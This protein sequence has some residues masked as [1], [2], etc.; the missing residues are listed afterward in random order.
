MVDKST[1]KKKLFIIIFGSDTRSGR[2]FD[3][4]LLISIILS[5]LVVFIDSV[6]YYHTNY[7]K[8]L[9]IAEWFFTV[10]F[11]VEYILRIITTKKKFSYI[12]SFYGVIDFLSIIPTYVSLVL[13]GTQ[14]LIV[15]RILRLLRV[16]RI[17]KL[18]RFIG[19]SS[20]LLASL[21]ASWHK[22]M[23]FLSV[24][25]TLVVIMGALM[26]LIE[27]QESGFSSIPKGIYWAIVTL[28]TVGYGDIAPQTFWG[29]T[30][31]SMIMILGYSIIAV[32][33]GIITAEMSRRRPTKNVIPECTHCNNIDHDD[34]AVYCKKCGKKLLK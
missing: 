6:G 30:L 14:F 23:V 11:T 10:L 17:L 33:T 4:I 12:F 29:Q 8:P 1:W 16:F 26:Y 31:A 19:A 13:S 34:D 2:L 27:G 9:Y 25:L 5:V 7:G 22:I 21:K 20:Y 32:P 18:D 28:T 3:I 15:I 24:I